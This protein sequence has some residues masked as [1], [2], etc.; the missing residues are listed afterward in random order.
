MRISDVYD[1]LNEYAPFS[2]SDEMQK[3]DGCYDNSGIIADLSDDVTGILFSLDL[4][5]KAVE[6]AKE[7]GCNLIVTHH[8]AIYHPIKSVDGALLSAVKNGVG[9]IS[10]HLNLDCA[11]RGIDY[12]FASGLGAERQEILLKL[13]GDEVGYGRRFFVGKSLKEIRMRAESVFNTT[14]LCYGADDMHVNVAASF[15]G[16]GLSEREVDTDCQ[17]LCSA[18]VEHHVVIKAVEQGKAVIV[19]T[20]YSCENYG[21][22]KLY[23]HFLKIDSLKN[24]INL[25]FFDDKR[26]F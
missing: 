1:I 18:E 26:L 3:A 11:K 25:V 14:V 21:F 19:F 17:L 10:C 13:S 12:Y 16:A 20:H 23:E 24:Q 15:C 9:V 6:R 2:L 4:T 22:M 8:P 5:N 7:Q